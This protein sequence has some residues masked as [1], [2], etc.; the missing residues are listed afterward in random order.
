MNLIALRSPEFRLY[1]IGAVANVNAM[2]I[3]RII[4]GWLAWDIT[5]S[6]QFVGI[7]AAC[8]L[9]PTL[10]T[11]P[12][13]GVLVD[14]ADVRKAAYCTNISMILCIGGL[15]SLQ[16]SG[17]VSQTTLVLVSL[18]IGTVTAAHHPVRL[19]LGPRLVEKKHVSSVV[20]L[21]ALNFNL[22]RLISP[23]VG[24]ILIDVVGITVALVITVVMFLPN[25]AVLFRLHPRALEKHGAEP[26]TTA[27]ATGLRY[28]RQRRV[29][30]VILLST[31]VFSIALR[32]VL[33]VLPIVADG[34]F[35]RGAVGLGQLGSAVGAGALC[36]AVYKTLHNSARPANTDALSPFNL[37]V[38]TAGLVAIGLIGNTDTWAVALA[39]A[40]V[41]GASGTY[42]GVTMQ[43][44]IQ[45]DLPDDM[46]GRVMSIWV[47][48]G[49]G[50]TALGA[51]VLGAL[52]D[53]IGLS[54][55][56]AGMA[57]FGFITLMSLSL[58]IHR[59]A[60]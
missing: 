27:M 46:R 23:A 49:L 39:C 17:M 2:W 19:S 28:I 11:G 21:S 36:S 30:V 9:V 53:I 13:F 7:V 10:V 43:S 44:L 59:D 48:V 25:L 41:L 32:G 33:E 24:G 45:T 38:A 3:A 6:A 18:A 51:F 34:A 56:S 58:Y 14:R 8:S 52:A 5:H 35:G 50:S 15:L 4:L 26:F 42:F 1:F 40:A 60:K 22:A 57:V 47:V 54:L 29:I 20:A 31:T 55:S 12:F 16:A 37:G